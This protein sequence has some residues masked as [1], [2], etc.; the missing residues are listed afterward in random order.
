MF[1]ERLKGTLK[2]TIAGTT[3]T[4][5]AGNL[6]RFEIELTPWGYRGFAEWWFICVSSPSED[7]LF[8]SFVGKD[9]ISVELSLARAFSEVA[10]EVEEEATALVLKGLVIEKSA[11]ERSFPEVTGK[12]VLHRRYTIRFADRGAVLWS[13]HRPSV[14]YVDKTL[15]D[16][17]EDNKPTGVT[18]EHAWAASSP[19]HPVLALGLGSAVN[20]ASYYDFLFWLFDKLNVGFFYDPA[21]D[22]YKI[23]DAKSSGTAI[24]LRRAEVEVMECV[25]PPI[26]RDAVAVLN[27]YSDAGTKKKDITNADGVTGVRTDY[28]IRSAIAADLDT[29]ATLETDRAKQ[30]EPEARVTLKLFPAVPFVPG[31]LLK[32]D[33]EWS[34]KVFQYGK[35]YRIV[36]VRLAGE[37]EH[38]QATMDDRDATNRYQ[39]DYALQLELNSDPVVRHPPFR[40]PVWPFYVEGKVLSEVG[41]DDEL[42]FQPYP[43]EQTS[44]EY[45]KVKIPL[46]EDQKVIVPYEPITHPGHFFFPLYKD[47]RA[48]V[49]LYFDKARIRAFLDWRPGGRLPTDSQGNHLLVGKKDKNQTSISHVYED[50]KPVMTIKRTLEDD[51][52]TITISEGM[53]R[54]E[55]RD[56]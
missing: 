36:T 8:T 30:H 25:F 51:V 54:W 18:I 4:V 41:A 56:H 39:L 23:A 32:L 40:R 47:E 46:W 42:T 7:T 17:I 5:P 27:A 11:V 16:L 52:Q 19:T 9:L 3:T 28:L 53:I 35:T 13:Q 34:T 21:G 48:L 26:H 31:M 43:D 22:K 55:T 45:Y 14:L 44:L 15:K 12:P 2:L 50:Q 33:S 37:A 24:D 6:K 29:R 49:A 20:D 10:E 38:Q 1:F